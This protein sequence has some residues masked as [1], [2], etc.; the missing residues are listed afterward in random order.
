MYSFFLKSEVL[1]SFCRDSLTVAVRHAFEILMPRCPELLSYFLAF[2]LLVGAISTDAGQPVR[3]DISRRNLENFLTDKEALT[4]YLRSDG[5]HSGLEDVFTLGAIDAPFAV[6]WDPQAC[7]LI[8]ILNLQQSKTSAPTPSPPTTG[9]S[10][11]GPNSEK[12]PSNPVPSSTEPYLLKAE[13][14]FPLSKTIGGGGSPHFFGFRI[15]DG[16]P[17]FLYLCGLLH[18]EERLWLEDEGRILKQRFSVTH[19]PKGLEIALP[20]QWQNRITTSVGTVKNGILSVPST[21]TSEVVITY[22]L[23]PSATSQPGSHSTDSN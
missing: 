21:A 14:P 1:L 2:A 16:K 12:V 11:A 17:E 10:P 8:G 9:A 3:L 7:R 23:I 6:F 5:S 15:V 22:S 13:G 4:P 18:I 20:L 19:A